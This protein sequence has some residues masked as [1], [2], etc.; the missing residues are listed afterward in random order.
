L[1]EAQEFDL[2]WGSTGQG[3]QP[4]TA[5]FISAVSNLFYWLAL[6]ALVVL[7]AGAGDPEPNRYDLGD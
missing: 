3:G 4:E 7:L 5:T 2:D 1:H 6:L